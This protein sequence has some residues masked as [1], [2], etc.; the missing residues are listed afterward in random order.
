M[1]ARDTTAAAE[2]ALGRKRLGTWNEV[3]GCR[4][5]Y[6][7]LL[8]REP[9]HIVTFAVSHPETRRSIEGLRASGYRTTT[10]ARKMGV[11]DLRGY[12]HVA[13][14]AIRA[15]LSGDAGTEDK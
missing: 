11:R 4:G 6:Y 14:E 10:L 5:W 1:T 9:G 12:E 7:G 13:R 8:V 15:V 3:R 2:R